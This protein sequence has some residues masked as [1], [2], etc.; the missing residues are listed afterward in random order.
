MMDPC[1][2]CNWRGS[3]LFHNSKTEELPFWISTKAKSPATFD[4]EV[5]MLFVK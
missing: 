3:I 2:T 5:A 4:S 1:S